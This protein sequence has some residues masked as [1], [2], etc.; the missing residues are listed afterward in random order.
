MRALAL[1]NQKGG[2]G[3]TTTAIHLGHGLAMAGLTVAIFDLDPQGNATLALQEALGRSDDDAMAPLVAAG[4][5]LW[6][7]P[8]AGVDRAISPSE[9]LD[10]AGLEQLCATLEDSVDVLLVDCPPRMDAWGWAGL[11]LCSQVL[12]PVQAEF[13]AMHGLTR[14]LD[15]LEMAREQTN[16]SC[17][18]LGVFISMFDHREQIA[19]DVRADLSSNLGDTLLDTVVV[20]DPQFIEAASHGVSLFEY[21]PLAKGA[22]CYAS[23]VREVMGLWNHVPRE[24]THGKRD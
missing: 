1:A 18:L 20:R 5:G 14:M 19:L 21:N 2:V 8:S 12:V 11:R 3:K 15:T 24:T 6:L 7:L 10:V 16:R 17:E 13:F 9:H 22:R 23:L 4:K